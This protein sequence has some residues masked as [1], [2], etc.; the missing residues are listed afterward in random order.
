MKPA[1]TLVI[2]KRATGYRIAGIA[3][4]DM[5]HAW[6]IANVLV[7]G[8]RRGTGRTCRP[9]IPRSSSRPGSYRRRPPPARASRQRESSWRHRPPRPTSG[10][11]PRPRSSRQK[12]FWTASTMNSRRPRL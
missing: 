11:G 9:P 12:P 10:A 6:A 8:R 2:R 3:V 5:S 7:R 1:V 4:D